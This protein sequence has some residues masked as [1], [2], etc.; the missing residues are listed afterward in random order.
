MFKGFFGYIVDVNPF[1]DDLHRSLLPPSD[2]LPTASSKLF[3]FQNCYTDLHTLCIPCRFTI[4]PNRTV[5]S[6]SSNNPTSKRHTTHLGRIAVCGTHSGEDGFCGVCLHGV[7]K[8]M[9]GKGEKEESGDS[10]ERA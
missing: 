1:W 6:M 9:D 2:I 7:E 8:K 3:T 4:Q 5:L 10:E